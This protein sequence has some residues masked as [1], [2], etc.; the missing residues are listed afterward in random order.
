M[1][2]LKHLI[3]LHWGTLSLHKKE[4]KFYLLW[5]KPFHLSTAQGKSGFSTEGKKKSLEADR[6]RDTIFIQQMWVIIFM[7]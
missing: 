3:P 7:K 2:A 4:Q 5:Y 6:S 1:R